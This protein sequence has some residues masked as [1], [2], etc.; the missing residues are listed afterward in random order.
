MSQM[1]LCPP[2]LSKKF[3]IAFWTVP[4][5]LLCL[6]AVIACVLMHRFFLLSAAVTALILTARFDQEHNLAGWFAVRFRYLRSPKKYVRAADRQEEAAARRKIRQQKKEMRSALPI[7][8]IVSFR[9]NDDS[10]ERDGKTFIFYRW[11]PPNTSIMTEQ[12]ISDEILQLGRLF[13][14]LHCPFRV[15]VTDKMENLA[16]TKRY[17]SSLSAEFDYITS[18]IV[19]S[20]ESN[21]MESSSVQRA[22]YFIYEAKESQEKNDIYNA[23][24]GRGYHIVKARKS[25]IAVLL[26]NYYVREFVNT[27]IY[28]IAQEVED[29]PGMQKAKREIYD[30]EI[31]RRLTPH[32]ITF[33]VR[34]AHTGSCLRRT[35]MVKNFPSSI[36][37]CAFMR[38]AGMRGTSFS[39]CLTPMQQSLARNLIERQAKNRRASSSSNSITHQIDAEQDTQDIIQ[40]YSEMSRKKNF[41]YYV[42]IYIEMYG[43]SVEEL[44][45]LQERVADELLGMGIT[46]ES[47]PH[48]QR[49]AFESVQP[50][51]RD[52]FLG[53]ANSLPS[54]TAAACYPCSYSSRS[55]AHGMPLGRTEQGGNAIVDFWRWDEYITNA[56]AVVIGAPGQGKSWLLK[57]IITFMYIS[58]VR[59]YVFDP[60][61]EYCD[62]TKNLG[63]TVINC[64]SGTVKIN[65]FEVR[66]IITKDDTEEELQDIGID[67]NAPT[68]FQHLSWLADFFRVLFSQ[69]SDKDQ[70]A[71]MIFVQEMYKNHGITTETDFDHL[72]HEDYPTM[73]DLYKTIEE[74]A[75]AGHP[76][77]AEESIKTLQL[78]LYDAAH[79]SLGQL[80]NGTTNICND[81]LVCFAMR[82]LLDG[83][84]DRKQAVLFNIVT[85]IFAVMCKRE[86]KVLMEIDEL[87]MFIS[88]RLLVNYLRS[89]YKRSRKYKGSIISATQQ[90]NDC[91]E[92]ELAHLT[93]AIVDCSAFKMLFYPG[94]VDLKTME[95]ALNLTDGEIGCISISNKK[96]CLLK[97]GND[98]YHVEV[99]ALP[100]EA[101]LFGKG[102]GE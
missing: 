7:Q 76:F 82:E 43:K 54:Q 60:E 83:G 30:K 12:E 21:D 97:A 98:V 58:M 2:K 64:A 25:E 14:S 1:Y 101:A 56:N 44:N 34:E 61:N 102:G 41:V 88:N 81:R 42:N 73:A 22:Y 89:F 77:I 85:Y 29:L 70:R 18:D 10:V 75:Q 65:P 86:S 27:D 57:K 37:A 63:G 39:M 28:T 20:I 40:F 23:I 87:Y 96:H 15:F 47:L 19:H 90:L 45:I 92:G 16:E 33:A 53:D 78:Y 48:E 55:D 46:Y 68:F 95:K 91:L 31:Q 72:Q 62:L 67:P 80:L 49:D 38:L 94:S 69:L 26:R 50:L 99:G 71:L 24:S 52:K 8:K 35:I 74:A 3:L 100:Y 32:N 66:V 59:G 4:E 93:R 84:E 36:P 17:Y 5:L 51:G 6:L 13:D 79:G 11:S 9:L